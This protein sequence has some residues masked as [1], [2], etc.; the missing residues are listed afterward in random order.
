[1]KMMNKRI[2]RAAALSTILVV[3]GAATASAWTFA[4]QGSPLKVYSRGTLGGQAAGSLTKV[5]AS[6]V[7]LASQLT[8]NKTNGDRAYV[9]VRGIGAFGDGNVES[10]RRDDGGTSWA[11]MSP[12]YMYGTGAAGFTF[13]VKV[14]EDDSGR[15]DPCSDN[16]TGRL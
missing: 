3:S 5:N 10:G 6:Q 16:K 7:K 14:C 15:P 2:A 9:T 4:T 8:D 12:K 13:Y 11:N 1:M